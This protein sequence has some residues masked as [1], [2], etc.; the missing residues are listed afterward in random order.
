MLD[1]ETINRITKEEALDIPGRGQQD[2]SEMAE[3]R[4]KVRV[5]VAEA[6]AAGQIIDLVNE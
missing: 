6:K 3:F 4:A 2:T 1:T 5:E